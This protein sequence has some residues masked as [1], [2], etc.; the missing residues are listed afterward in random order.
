L[1]V[2]AAE[3]RPV[4]VMRQ[5]TGVNDPR[6]PLAFARRE[7]VDEVRTGII[8]LGDR[9][10]L[11]GMQAELQHSC[12]EKRNRSQSRDSEPHFAEFPVRKLVRPSAGLA[13][14]VRPEE[15][16]TGAA[17]PAGENFPPHCPRKA[18]P[19]MGSSLSLPAGI[20]S[21]GSPDC[22]YGLGPAA[23]YSVQAL[24]RPRPKPVIVIEEEHGLATSLAEPSVAGGRPLR[25][26]IESHPPDTGIALVLEPDGSV[27]LRGI[28]DDNE[29]PLGETLALDALNRLAE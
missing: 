10:G 4:A 2:L 9:S 27:V 3:P 24:E 26:L 5:L 25:M 13:N 6:R 8:R 15:R 29:L 7:H 18:E 16:L 22:R 28:V 17:I 23:K 20:E 19:R 1:A 11:A 12:G 21:D 14:T